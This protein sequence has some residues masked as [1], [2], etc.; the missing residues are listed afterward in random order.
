MPDCWAICGP[1]QRIT[2]MKI[3][4]NLASSPF[5]RDRAMVVASL[6]VCA[7]LLVTLGLLANLA[8]QDSR[9]IADVQHEV[10]SL[11][12]QIK[13]LN[14]QQAKLDA[15]VK[16]PEN[17]SVLERSVFINALLRRKG[18]SW[19]RIFTDLEKTIPYNV[20]IVRV[21]PTIDNGRVMLD[22]V[23]AA[24][25]PMDVVQ[26]FKSFAAS[27]LFGVAEP[28]SSQPPTQAEPLFRETLMVPY[29]QKL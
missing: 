28:K 22:M 3:P 2:E 27:P 1:L 4:I 12:Q 9:Q 17:A 18:I 14:A 26:M 11:Q 10:K 7:L 24:A 25:T 6:A 15:V 23:V 29:A 21:H 8:L 5:R 13:E 19:N 20:K 16:Q